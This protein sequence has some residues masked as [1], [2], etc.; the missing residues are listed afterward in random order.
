MKIG[1]LVKW[2]ALQIA[3]NLGQA[4]HIKDLTDQRQC[5]IIIDNNPMYFFIRWENGEVLAQ[6]EDELV[7][8]SESR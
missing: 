2:S 7:V 3:W 5:G 1:D 8:V 4:F 6:K